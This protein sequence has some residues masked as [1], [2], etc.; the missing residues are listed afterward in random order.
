MHLL[1][2]L[3]LEKKKSG[4]NGGSAS[5]G[6]QK[7]SSTKGASGGGQEE[8]EEGFGDA[9]GDWDV[10]RKVS[11][12][13]WESEAELEQELAEVNRILSQYD[14]RDSDAASEQM[15]QDWNQLH[16]AVDQ[17]RVPELLFQPSLM[18]EC[19]AG[20]VEVLEDV[21]NA[22][23]WEERKRLAEN[24]LIT[25]GLSRIPGMV[26]RFRKELRTI[27]PAEWDV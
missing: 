24:C 16:F 5:G 20:I 22:Y 8:E 12:D 14:S 23:P 17:A 2:E 13:G 1:F 18:G 3:G 10:Y 7:R 27:Y 4:G 15:E 9:E 6:P 25:G 26:G 11:K 19:S 21:L